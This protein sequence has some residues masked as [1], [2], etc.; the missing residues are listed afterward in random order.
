VICTHHK[1]TCIVTQSETR[2]NHHD[3]LGGRTAY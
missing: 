3:I 1:G 2:Y